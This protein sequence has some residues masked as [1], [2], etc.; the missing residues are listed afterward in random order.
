[1]GS[2]PKLDLPWYKHHLVGLD[3]DIK[4]RPFTVKEQKILLRA[5]ESNDAQDMVDAMKQITELCTQDVVADELPF[6]DLEDIFL[7][8]RTKSVSEVSEIGYK[9]KDT[10]EK[11]SVQINLD[12]VKVTKLPEHEKKIMLTDTVGVVMKYPTLEMLSGEATTDEDMILNC[13]D[14]V[15]DTEEVY[16]FKDVSKEEAQEWVENFDT[17]VMLKIHKFFE[18]MP[19]LRHEVEI[20]LKDGTKETLKFEGIQDLFT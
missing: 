18:T 10:D 14:Y 20:E 4:Y 12:D 19:R 16:H 1:M 8:I 15:F 17:S 13:I 7:R 11:I 3:K 5:K 2:L 9:V 6:F